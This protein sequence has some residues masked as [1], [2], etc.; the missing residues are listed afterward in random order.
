MNMNIRQNVFS[1]LK[2]AM[3]KKDAKVISTLRLIM[4]AI[5]D[6]D[7]VLKGNGDASGIDETAIILLMQ[8]M[9]KQRNAS[10]VLFKQGIR[11]DLVKIE[12]DEIL[13]IS[14]FLPKQL[15]DQEIEDAVVNAIK[16]TQSESI[17]DMGKVI[18][19]MKQN[20]IG[21]MDFR[22]VSAVVKEKLTK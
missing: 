18:N 7:I 15:N 3:I 19:L 4:A 5:K 22:I 12:E 1:A 17:K 8:T 10:I 9:I 6:K 14:S 13:I 20:Y 16:L 21:K 11:E 2:A